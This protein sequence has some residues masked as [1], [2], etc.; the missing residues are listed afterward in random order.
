MVIVCLLQLSRC[1]L[2]AGVKIHL[3]GVADLI[4]SLAFGRRRVEDTVLLT[5]I[6]R[7]ISLLTASED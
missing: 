1:L 6:Q 7:R 3:N 2:T 4:P 5:L